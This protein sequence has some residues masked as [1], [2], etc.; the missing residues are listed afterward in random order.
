M[1]KLSLKLTLLLVL[2]NIIAFVLLYYVYFPWTTTLG[3][4]QTEKTIIQDARKLN[5][6]LAENDY[7]YSELDLD[8]ASLDFSTE[9]R[10]LSKDQLDISKDSL[11]ELDKERYIP[12]MEANEGPVAYIKTKN[13]EYLQLGP[14]PDDYNVITVLD[15]LVYALI[16]SLLNYA[17]VFSAE[18]Y[19]KR[20][21]HDANQAVNKLANKAVLTPVAD[22]LDNV[23]DNTPL[24]SHYIFTLQDSHHKN[25]QNQRDL[26]HA[27]AHE[28]RGPMARINFA[29]DLLTNTDPKKPD[30]L[31]PE[32]LKKDIEEA[33]EEL[34]SLV[35]E[36]LDYSRLKDGLQKLTLAEFNI[37]DLIGASISKVEPFYSD[38]IIQ[39][40]YLPAE[41]FQ[42]LLDQKLVERAVLNLIR[43]AA[44]FSRSEVT[45]VAKVVDQNRFTIIVEDDG[46]GVPPG[47]RE[48]IFEP[49][50]RLDFSR[51]RDSGGAGLGLAIVNSVAIRHQGSIAVE[52]SEALG[53]AKFTLS[54]PLTITAGKLN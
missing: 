46:T 34:D 19:L 17:C 51:N 50:T 27:V 14:Y 28:F 1:K 35:K 12:Y 2:T 25:I 38:K 29:I 21:L 37:S 32:N 3:F 15:W 45:I 40:K 5:L 47:K 43:N 4:E 36:V 11:E 18:S 13:Q 53:G 33:L 8:R 48:R 44:K 49:F 16:L 7:Q 30:S 23:A 42:C 52:H 22:Q 31:K 10:K 39:A 20:R 26:M 6:Q 24:L 9:I 54:L 41:G